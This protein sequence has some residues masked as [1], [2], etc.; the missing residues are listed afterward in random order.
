MG[1]V[2]MRRLH[3]FAQCCAGTAQPCEPKGSAEVAL[4]PNGG[5]NQNW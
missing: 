3:A 4:W 1:R 5:L 2:D